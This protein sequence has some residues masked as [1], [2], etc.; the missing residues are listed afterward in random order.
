RG[1]GPARVPRSSGRRAS[2]RRGGAKGGGAE[3]R[4]CEK[5][6]RRR[7][8]QGEG[9]REDGPGSE[10]EGKEITRPPQRPRRLLPPT[11]AEPPPRWPWPPLGSP[12]VEYFASVNRPADTARLEIVA[13]RGTTTEVR[14]DSVAIEEPFEIRAEGPGRPPTRIAVTMRT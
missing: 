6:S 7:E 13:V 4:R 5:G 11:W 10:E 9:S 2:R 12:L 3:G 8:G 14:D 1:D